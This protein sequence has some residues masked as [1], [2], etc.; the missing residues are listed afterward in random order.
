MNK[1]IILAIITILMCTGLASAMQ[2]W[3]YQESATVANQT[4]IDGNCGQ[5]YTGNYGYEPSY[6]YVNYTVPSGGV[7]TWKWQ[8]LHGNWTVLYRNDTAPLDPEPYNISSEDMCAPIDGKLILRF[9]TNWWYSGSESRP[10]CYNGTDWT[11]IGQDRISSYYAGCYRATEDNIP[12]FYDGDWTTG[13]AYSHIGW[14][15]GCGYSTGTGFHSGNVYEEAMYWGVDVQ[16]LQDTDCGSCQYCNAG[17]CENQ[18][19]TDTKGDCGFCQWCDGSGSCTNEDNGADIRHECN[20]YICIDNCT[21]LAGGYCNGYGECDNYTVLVHEGH[22]CLPDGTEIQ[23]TADNH[24]G[25]WNNCAAGN[26]AADQYYVGCNPDAPGTCS[27]WLWYPAG[28]N[29]TAP[30]GYRIKVTEHAENCSI[31][32]IPVVHHGGGGGGFPEETTT[33]AATPTTQIPT[34]S[35]AGVVAGKINFGDLIWYWIKTFIA[36]FGV[37][38]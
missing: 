36:G 23:P 16:C 1:A 35:I 26:T 25:I 33:P 10:E 3:C 38:I 27:D 7:T 28:T 5:S 14:A 15:E 12:R 11:I 18:Y 21:T 2:G 9:Y 24:C 37:K 6:L 22:V 20:Y 17:T 8:V 32:A 13:V 4:G 34:F 19:Q 29:W 30:T 31:E